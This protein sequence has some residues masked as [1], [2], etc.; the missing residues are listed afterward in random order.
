MES[1]RPHVAEHRH[2]RCRLLSANRKL[3]EAQMSERNKIR[4]DIEK[5]IARRATMDPDFRDALLKDPKRAVQSLLTDEAPG[6]TLP[7]NLE[8]KAFAEPANAFYVVVPAAP[9]SLSEAD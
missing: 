1:L 5:S 7:A 4:M 3:K 8:V 9:A 2:T 6:V